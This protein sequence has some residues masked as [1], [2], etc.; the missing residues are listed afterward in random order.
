MGVGVADR[1]VRWYFIGCRRKHPPGPDLGGAG[2]QI[3]SG[4]KTGRRLLW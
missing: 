1:G 3:H 2:A 4:E